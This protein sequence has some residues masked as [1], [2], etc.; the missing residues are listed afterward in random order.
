MEKETA[1]PP[2]GWWGPCGTCGDPRGF[3]QNRAGF[4]CEP[5]HRGDELPVPFIC[6]I[7]GNEGAGGESG[8][9]Q[10]CYR[11]NYEGPYDD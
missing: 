2:E 6:E 9:C 4:I 11:D 5:C 8:L 3:N 10:P 1:A 7:C